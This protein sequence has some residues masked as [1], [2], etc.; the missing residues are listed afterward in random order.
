M[1]A[2]RKLKT[3]Q[4]V[5]LGVAGVA[6]AYALY[7][8]RQ[9]DTG[10]EKPSKLPE[11]Q[12]E[13]TLQE[14]A[15]PLTPDRPGPGVFER[16]GS[17]GPGLGRIIKRQNFPVSDNSSLPP[18]VRGS[19]TDHGDGTFTVRFNHANGMVS[20]THH[21]REAAELRLDSMVKKPSEWACEA[22]YDEAFDAWICTSGVN[23]GDV[24][25]RGFHDTERGPA[26]WFVIWDGS[27]YI[28]AFMPDL[29]SEQEELGRHDELL[30]AIQAASGA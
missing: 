8:W 10:T 25:A 4:K 9:K 3:W 27:Q 23:A 24:V 30:P 5:A 1:Q 29:H 28:A 11:T 20:Y 16:P 22:S 15:P 19:I 18:P 14:P 6:G 13:P 17:G 26:P 7:R 2:L 21:S 12:E